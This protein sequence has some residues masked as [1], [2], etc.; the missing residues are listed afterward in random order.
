LTREPDYRCVGRKG[1]ACPKTA[2]VVS[3]FNQLLLLEKGQKE[4]SP[5]LRGFIGVSSPLFADFRG[6]P[7]GNREK[8]CG[9]GKSQ[10]QDVGEAL[11]GRSGVKG[12]EPKVS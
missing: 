7:E 1:I 12:R 6:I 10:N 8:Q 2:Y 3:N 4:K 5:F 11:H 9:N